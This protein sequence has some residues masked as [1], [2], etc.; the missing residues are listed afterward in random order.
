MGTAIN[1]KQCKG[2]KVNGNRCKINAIFGGYC[3]AHQDQLRK[4]KENEDE[5][6]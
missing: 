1:Y 2:K 5:D 3:Y 4:E 6:K